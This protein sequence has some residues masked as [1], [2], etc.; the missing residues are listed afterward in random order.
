MEI[1]EGKFYHLLEEK[2]ETLVRIKSITWGCWDAA[3]KSIESPYDNLSGR[4][5]G[6]EHWAS[7]FVLADTVGIGLDGRIR[8]HTVRKLK[9]LI[10]HEVFV[11]ELPLYV[12]WP[13]TSPMLSKILQEEV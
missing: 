1:E 5:V 11:K 9:S 2:R 4:Y 12:S 10:D 8:A 6:W 13:H 3:T 7:A